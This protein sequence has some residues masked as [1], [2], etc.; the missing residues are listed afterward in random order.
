MLKAN[1]IR[2]N[3]DLEMELYT[4]IVPEID[5]TQVLVKVSGSP[6]IPLS[7]LNDD[8]ERNFPFI[9]GSEAIGEVVKIGGKAQIEYNVD[10]GDLVFVEPVILCK[11]CQFC[12]KGNYALCVQKKYYGHL[13]ADK[14]PYLLGSYSQYMILL[15]GSRVHKLKK[16][17]PLEK[18]ALA[19]LVAKAI[20]C[21]LKK[22]EGGIGKSISILGLN[23]FSIACALVAKIAGLDP[24]VIVQEKIS[25]AE[26]EITDSLEI[27][28]I[29]TNATN[30]EFNIVIQSDY[31]KNNLGVNN[32]EI[33]NQIAPE[34]KYIIPFSF[35]DKMLSI[36]QS[37]F[38]KKELDLL[39]I[40]NY[41][42]E[43]EKALQMIENYKMP[44]EKIPYKKYSLQE[45]EEYYQ[46]DNVDRL[47][48]IIVQPNS[49]SSGGENVE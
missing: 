13:P 7:F 17:L 47:L 2:I 10:A 33:Y 5:E 11:K 43:F 6:F 12:L 36:S 4:Y 18:Y 32:E 3:K 28:I 9:P 25:P 14:E 31:S 37:Q 40:S 23:N 21:I 29:N 44:L 41:S 24:V 16:D 49:K 20:K 48:N 39:G 27:D 30:K 42:W 15:K 45:I 46:K 1:S 19:G 38:A 34:G 22:G 26:K 8:T 35:P